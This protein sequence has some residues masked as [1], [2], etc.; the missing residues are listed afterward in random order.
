MRQWQ[1]MIHHEILTYYMCEWSGHAPSNLA[2]VAGR[3]EERDDVR[4]GVDILASTV[5]VREREHATLRARGAARVLKHG[6]AVVARPPINLQN[7]RYES[8]PLEMRKELFSEG[9]V[10]TLKE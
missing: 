2:N 7:T 1:H 8:K 5:L 9:V 3:A 6:H 4:A 10:R